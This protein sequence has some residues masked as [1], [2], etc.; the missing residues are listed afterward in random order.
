MSDS[1]GTRSGTAPSAAEALRSNAADAMGKISDAAQ[2][3]MGEAK[4][5]ASSLAA[6]AT[7]RAKG[8]AQERISDGADFIGHVAASIRAAARDLDP[9]APQ[10]AG[11][12]HEAADRI[13]EF[14]RDIRTKTV[15]ELFETTSDFARRQPAMLFAA[16][17]ACGFFLF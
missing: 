9:N 10:V 7:E 4:K 5:S 1:T 11:F 15:E 16:A 17:A 8:A 13:D 12:V 2:Q 3:A 14:S 6:A